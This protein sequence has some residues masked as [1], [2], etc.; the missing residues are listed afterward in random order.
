MDRLMALNGGTIHRALVNRAV[1]LV[2]SAA[3]NFSTDRET[4]AIPG[5][6][7]SEDVV[8][9]YFFADAVDLPPADDSIQG[10]PAL[11]ATAQILDFLHKEPLKEPPQKEDENWLVLAR[12]DLL[13]LSNRREMLVQILDGMAGGSKARALPAD[14]PEWGHVDRTASFWGLRHYSAKSKPIRGQRGF[15]AAELPLPDAAATGVTVQFDGSKQRLEIHYLSTNPLS[16]LSVVVNKRQRDFSADQPEAG[17][18]R[19]ISEVHAPR[20]FPIYCALAMLGFGA[21][22]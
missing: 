4:V 1:R 7:G 18:W 9:F 13:L 6:A 15:D 12:P 21:Y 17:V 16:E 20:L 11:R 8:Y 5:F 10:H 22:R 19:L 14:L 3:R 2:V